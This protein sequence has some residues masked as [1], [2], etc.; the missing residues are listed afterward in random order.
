MKPLP[1]LG[2]G[3]GEAFGADGDEDVLILFEGLVLFVFVDDVFTDFDLPIADMAFEDVDRRGAKE[4]GDEEV[5]RVV[6][7]VLRGVDLLHFA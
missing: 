1:F 2:L 5:G 3:H 6:V 7:D 4:H